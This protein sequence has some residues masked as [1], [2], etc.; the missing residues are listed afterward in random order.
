MKTI[1]TPDFFIEKANEYIRQADSFLEKNINSSI[2]DT[3][4]MSFDDKA[5]LRESLSEIQELKLKIRLLL[6]EFENGCLFTNNL[7]NEPTDARQMLAKSNK[8]IL[9]SYRRTL[10]LFIEHLKEFRL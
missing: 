9:N 7:I 8:D 6:S 2:V 10:E 5:K 3:R 1:K 4:L